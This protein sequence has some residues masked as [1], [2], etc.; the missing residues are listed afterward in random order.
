MDIITI[1]HDSIADPIAISI[2]DVPVFDFALLSN[3]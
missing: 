2:P 1:C 3:V